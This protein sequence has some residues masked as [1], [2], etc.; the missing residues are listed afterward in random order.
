MQKYLLILLLLA[1]SCATPRPEGKTEAEILFKEAEA[2]IKNESYILGSEKLREIKARF[3]YSKYSQMAQLRLADVAFTQENYI[4]A[5]VAYQSY[6]DLYPGDD[7]IPYV[8]FKLGEAFYY[9]LP[10]THDRDLSEAFQAIAY[11]KQVISR[12]PGS[13][14]VEESKKKIEKCQQM[15]RDKEQYIADFYF[16]TEVYEAARFR[17]KRILKMFED[18]K[19]LKHSMLR[20]VESSLKLKEKDNCSRDASAFIGVLSNDE[21]QTRNKLRNLKLKCEDL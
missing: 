1:V 17:Y 16:K 5:A 8:V 21:S 18:D 14:Y 3:P 4:E 15:L 6:K 19:L 13:E 2:H 9:Q 20:A 10:P 7:K 11:Y 12:Y